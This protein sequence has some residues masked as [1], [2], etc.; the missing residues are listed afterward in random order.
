ME[1]AQELAKNNQPEKMEHKLRRCG[2]IKHSL[3]STKDCPVGLTMQKA[4]KLA[5]GMALSKSEAKKT[6][7]DAAV[8]EDRICMAEEAAGENSKSDEEASTGS[9]VRMRGVS[10]GWITRICGVNEGHIGRLDHH[11]NVRHK[12]PTTRLLHNNSIQT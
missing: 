12:C 7:E 8:E 1:Q 5:L 2:F 11:G 6:V 9:V 4:K 10:A 3:V